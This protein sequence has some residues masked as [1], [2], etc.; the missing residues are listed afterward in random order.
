MN[1]LI[2]TPSRMLELLKKRQGN[3]I[4]GNTLRLWLAVLLCGMSSALH[5]TSYTTSVAGDLNNKA[6]WTPVPPN[7]TTQSDT[8][9]ITLPMTVSTTWSVTG[10]VTIAKGGSIKDMGKTITF[11]G[12]FSNNADS[13]YVAT[14]TAIFGSEFPQAIGGSATTIFNNLTRSHNGLSFNTNCI[15]KSDFEG[16]S[17]I[18]DGGNTIYFGGNFTVTTG[19]NLFTG[20]AVFNGKNAQ[21][22]DGN[23]DFN[24]LT[25]SNAKGVTLKS[26][27]K[28][29]GDL[30]ITEGVLTDGGNSISVAKNIIGA[31]KESGSGGITL[32]GSA[33]TISGATL[34]NL[35][36]DNAAGFTL[37][38]NAVITGTLTF[39]AGSLVIGAN[40]LTLNGSVAGMNGSRFFTG[41]DAS[42]ITITATHD[43]GTLY[44]NQSASGV[45]NNVATLTLSG[46]EG[47]VTLGNKLSISNS[48][49]LTAGTLADGGNN[50]TL[51]GSITGNGTATGAG[52][53]TMKGESATISGATIG[54][55]E[56]N[57]PSDFSLTG[58]P[59]ITDALVMTAGTLTIGANTLTLNGSVSGMSAT[60]SLTGSATSNLV[61]GNNGAVDILF[62]DQSEDG[63]SNNIATLTVKGT[64]YSIVKLGNKLVSGK[65]VI[66]TKGQLQINDQTF[67]ING[68]FKGTATDNIQGSLGSN[69]IINARGNSGPYYFDQTTPGRTNNIGKLTINCAGGTVNI[70]SALN[71]SNELALDSGALADGGNVITVI[72]NIT[73]TGTATG[74]GGIVITGAAPVISGVTLSN[75]TIQVKNAATLS[76]NLT[77]NNILTMAS[78][79]L[80]IGANTMTLNGST[81]GMSG[82][83]SLIGGPDANL[84]I[85]SKGA[86]GTIYL[87]QSAKG[88][89]NT[90]AALKLVNDNCTVTMAGNVVVGTMNEGGKKRKKRK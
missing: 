78:G 12:H 50:I 1:D 83:N 19:N 3:A 67:V 68:G 80:S 18:V 43:L 13:G 22:I 49:A 58:S 4:A 64:G 46:K 85:G 71:V 7:F 55:L 27:E 74:T 65:T 26:D 28:V 21:T 86:F 33:A 10:N 5:A 77:V 76:G 84:T 52:G 57:H 48:L 90:L 70:G 35:T 31:G 11:N 36:L 29:L 30:T 45:S 16:K 88:S 23:P 8:W 15:I 38:G 53:I 61:I 66:L 82:K 6:N 9:T 37:T 75:L 47:T 20:T 63:V 51:L 42:N 32:T 60:N 24:N 59:T 14:G 72:G 69:L 2:K 87:D 81:E 62:F 40:T 17:F 34:E 44:F 79:K 56:L 73:G 41:S 89:S 54:K 39:K 25:I